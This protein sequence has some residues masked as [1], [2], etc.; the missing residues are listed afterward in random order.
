M[1]TT[2]EHRRVDVG[3]SRVRAG[4]AM[5]RLAANGALL[6]GPAHDSDRVLIVVFSK[7]EVLLS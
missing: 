1:Q 4:E 5:A 3:C 2:T 7:S 6:K